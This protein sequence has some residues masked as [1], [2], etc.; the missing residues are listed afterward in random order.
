MTPLQIRL[1]E[2]FPAYM[3]SVNYNLPMEWLELLARLK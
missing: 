3:E 2:L 1:A